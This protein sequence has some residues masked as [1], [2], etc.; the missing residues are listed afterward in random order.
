M[1]PITVTQS[2]FLGLELA[3]GV[4]GVDTR[5]AARTTQSQLQDTMKVDARQ[6]R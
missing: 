3:F 1:A 5:L 2:L 4:E 6:T